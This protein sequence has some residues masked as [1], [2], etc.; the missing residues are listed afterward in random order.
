MGPSPE[1][2]QSDVDVNMLL[3]RIEA[4]KAR[5]AAEDLLGDW[6]R[7]GFVEQA[8]IDRLAM[9]RQLLP[10][11]LAEVITFLRAIGAQA[12]EEPEPEELLLCESLVSESDLDR[13]PGKR[14]E[15]DQNAERLLTPNEVFELSNA[16]Q[17]GIQAARSSDSNTGL[18][19]E[20][21]RIIAR[22]QQARERMIICNQGLVRFVAQHFQVHP[23]F[24]IEDLNQEGILGL[25]TAIETYDP[26]RGCRFSTYAIWWIRQAILRALASRAATIRVPVHRV[27]DIF[28]FKRT[29]E[30]LRQEGSGTEPTIDEIAH[31]LQWSV[32]KVLT[33]DQLSQMAYVSM[34][35]FVGDND[36]TELGDTLS[37]NLP[38]P[39]DAF[40]AKERKTFV[41]GA[42]D[43]L[44][45]R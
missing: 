7:Q 39:V 36:D 15:R 31:A 12:D 2:A 3:A 9:I 20:Q 44:T 10:A 23:A 26:A 27:T 28:K 5:R 33:I 22:G 13:A 16:I 30:L 25:I 41:T 24:T 34:N 18:P 17:L 4:P 6:E 35:D 40:D 11:Q 38:S 45:R 19:V 32:E 43:R 29:V 8:Q 14:A 37:A 21:Q 1:T 42:L